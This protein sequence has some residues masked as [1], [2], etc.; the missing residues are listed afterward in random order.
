MLT[1]VNPFDNTNIVGSSFVQPGE[2]TF[3]VF[4]KSNNDAN[5]YNNRG[6][7]RINDINEIN[8][9]NN[10]NGYNSLT[11]TYN[12][13]GNNTC[14]D[15]SKK[16]VPEIDNLIKEL[17]IIRKSKTN[18]T[19][20]I[21]DK[22]I[23]DKLDR[24]S[25]QLQ[26]NHSISPIQNTSTSINT[27]PLTVPPI[28][29]TLTST[30]IPSQIITNTSTPSLFDTNVSKP[31]LLSDSPSPSQSQSQSPPGISD[32][33]NLELFKFNNGG[34][35]PPDDLTTNTKI[36]PP[37]YNNTRDFLTDKSSYD[38]LT[39]IN[40]N[41]KPYFDHINYCKSTL[42]N[43]YDILE[44]SAFFSRNKTNTTLELDNT[45]NPL[46]INSPIYNT[47]NVD[48]LGNTPIGFYPP[49]QK[50]FKDGGIDAPEEL[51]KGIQLAKQKGINLL[52][53]KSRNT[54]TFLTDKTYPFSNI[55]NVSD[56]KVYFD[57]INYC[58]A[59]LFAYFNLLQNPT[60][61]T[62]VK[63]TVGFDRP[64]KGGKTRKYQRKNSKNG[65]KNR[66]GNSR[67]SRKRVNRRRTTVKRSRR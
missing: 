34:L 30:P 61:S 65:N 10:I 37:K 18:D 9:S 16:T 33:L 39:V 1:N 59:T 2:K 43:F 51:K 54:E 36:L 17:S 63:R 12:I 21:V 49:E 20:M 6:N 31:N 11:D 27:L 62:R 55:F 29:S 56:L 40:A 19:T 32:T 7:N 41:F 60:M 53:E 14:G 38:F 42:L 15:L 45:I 24:L 22:R 64:N 58:K 23:L 66:N 67:K 46:N 28:I 5:Y 25:E 3:N 52:P 8:N 35:K 44:S 4:N 26:Q 47:S 57:H 50:V 13:R 48:L